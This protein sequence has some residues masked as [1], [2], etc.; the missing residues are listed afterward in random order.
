MHQGEATG[1]DWGR[2]I[3]PWQLLPDARGPVLLR[4]EFLAPG[5]LKG[6]LVSVLKSLHLFH[7]AHLLGAGGCEGGHGPCVLV[8]QNRRSEMGQC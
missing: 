2:P 5:L 1:L 4:N 7:G 8:Q 6:K 3:P